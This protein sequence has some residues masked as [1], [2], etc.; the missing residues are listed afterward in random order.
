MLQ[1]LLRDRYDKI[2]IDSHSLAAVSDALNVVPL[3]DAV[4]YVIKYDAVKKSLVNSCRRLWESKKPVLGAILNNVS[5]GLA[6][7]KYSQYSAN[8]K[9]SDYY[10]QATYLDDPED[11][12]KD[13]E[14]DLKMT[15]VTQMKCLK[16][17]F[18]E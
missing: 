3:I 1:E 15:Q 7:T 6:T 8:K 17:S 14:E 4:L 5:V 13:I 18:F 16:T 11:V 9:Y 12:S 10:M 2:I